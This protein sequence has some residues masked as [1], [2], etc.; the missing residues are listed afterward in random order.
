[1]GA[2]PSAIISNMTSESDG[3]LDAHFSA[4]FTLLLYCVKE[5]IFGGI[6]VVTCMWQASSMYSD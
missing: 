3:G 5:T 6:F 1:M 2:L 4:C